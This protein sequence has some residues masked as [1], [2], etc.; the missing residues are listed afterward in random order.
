MTKLFASIVLIIALL[1]VSGSDEPIALP[2]VC[3]ER[4]AGDLCVTV[5]GAAVLEMTDPIGRSI[6]Y[7][8]AADSYVSDIPRAIGQHNPL[9][10]VDSLPSLTGDAIEWS[11]AIDGDYILRVIAYEGG[12]LGL[13]VV[14]FDRDNGATGWDSWATMGA[15]DKL[16]FKIRFSSDPGTP[17]VVHG[18]APDSL[19]SCKEGSDNGKRCPNDSDE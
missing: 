17:V 2:K 16:R 5:C 6:R 19:G 4:T 8:A 1:I 15:G 7:D 9:Y 11:G 18:L 14:A 10:S 13:S 12:Q 3:F